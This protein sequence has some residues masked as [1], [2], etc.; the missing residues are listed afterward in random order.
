MTAPPGARRP[1]P[2]SFSDEESFG[3]FMEG[4]RELQLYEDEASKFESEPTR[5]LQHLTDALD[6]LEQC[7]RLFPDDLLPR[8]YLGIALTMQNQC[9]YASLLRDRQPSTGNLPPAAQPDVATPLPPLAERPWPLLDR[10]LDCFSRNGDFA[11]VPELRDAALFNSANVCV[12]LGTAK[13][14]DRA[15]EILEGLEK[16]RG[17]PRTPGRFDWLT[18][19]AITG[20][21]RQSDDEE[22]A[23]GLS[24]QILL[25]AARALRAIRTNHKAAQPDVDFAVQQLTQCRDQAG[26]QIADAVARHDVLADALTKRGIVKYF[27]AVAQSPWD[28]PRLAGAAP[29]PVTG[30]PNPP[31]VDA[32]ADLQEA[33]QHKSN[34]IPAQT[35]LAQVFQALGRPL[36]AEQQLSSVLGKRVEDAK[37]A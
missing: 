31:L 8:Y 19:W 9:F 3:L 30:I 11:L 6:A 26:D 1:A 27:F 4:V 22:K 10:A 13:S 17:R 37:V 23:L 20:E 28:V 12:R 25:S 33:L 14:Y 5:L 29:D 32:A 7:H 2:H 35:Y 21:Q 24:V 36:A 15:V 18:S 34:W 16:R